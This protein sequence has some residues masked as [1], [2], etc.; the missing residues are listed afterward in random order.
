MKDRDVSVLAEMGLVN[1]RL[2]VLEN[3]NFGDIILR[4]Q[5]FKS[6]W[7]NTAGMMTLSHLKFAF[8]TNASVTRV[9]FR[10][11]IIPLT[12]LTFCEHN[13]SVFL[14]ISF[15]GMF[16]IALVAIKGTVAVVAMNLRSLCMRGLCFT[17]N[18][19]IFAIMKKWPLK[20]FITGQAIRKFS[21]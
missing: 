20:R 4:L 6:E 8:V 21:V 19:S 2:N 16:I 3:K 13:A 5:F 18:T 11:V 12:V 1:A 10:S 17:A 9:G 15:Y 14:S 7:L